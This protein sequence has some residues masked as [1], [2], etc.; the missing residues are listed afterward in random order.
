MD[1]ISKLEKIQKMN[2]DQGRTLKFVSPLGN[3][4]KSLEIL[5]RSNKVAFDQSGSIVYRA[6]LGKG[7][8]KTWDELFSELIQ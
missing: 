5:T 7:S 2:D 4:L 6:S 1:N 8:A 3:S